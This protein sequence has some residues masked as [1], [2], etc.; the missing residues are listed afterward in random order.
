MDL[1]CLPLG[2]ADLQVA[3]ADT[4]GADQPLEDLLVFQK[5]MH[6]ILHVNSRLYVPCCVKPF[7]TLSV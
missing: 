1:Y 2:Q 6:M 5:S 7:P 4:E 3:E